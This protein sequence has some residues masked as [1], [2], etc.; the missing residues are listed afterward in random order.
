MTQDTSIEF[1]NKT[2]NVFVIDGPSQNRGWY[3]EKVDSGCKHCYAE[4]LNMGQWGNG[5]EFHGKKNRPVFRFKGEEIKAWATARKPRRNFVNDMT[6]TFGEFIS[7]DFVHW[8][9]SGAANAPKQFTY[10]FTKRIERAQIMIDNWLKAPERQEVLM[11]SVGSIRLPDNIIIVT[12]VSDQE[13]AEKRIPILKTIRG[14]TG[15]SFEPIVDRID[16]KAPKLAHALDYPIDWVTYGG[17]S[18]DEARPVNVNAVIDTFEMCAEKDIPQF[19]KQWGESPP[20]GFD[21]GTTQ[22]GFDL[23]TMHVSPYH[24]VEGEYMQRRVGRKEAG[25][26]LDGIHQHACPYWEPMGHG[27]TVV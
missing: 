7:E 16:W 6:D 27:L 25:S 17:E 11:S 21:T 24:D 4:R 20:I 1:T 12:S 18:G 5:K 2:E 23:K 3:C 22:T 19:F 15:I 8:L 14:R 26:M 9:L 13:S 10:L